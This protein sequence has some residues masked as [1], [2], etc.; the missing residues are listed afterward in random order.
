MKTVS[1]A[2]AR[3]PAM[4]SSTRSSSSGRDALRRVGLIRETA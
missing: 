2:F 4:A 1:F 3:E